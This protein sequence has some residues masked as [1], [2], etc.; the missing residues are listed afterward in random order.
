MIATLPQGAWGVLIDKLRQI[1]DD[2]DAR[3]DAGGH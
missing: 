1:L 3:L 2:I